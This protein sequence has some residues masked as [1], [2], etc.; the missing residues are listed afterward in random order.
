VEPCPESAS[1]PLEDNAA[2]EVMDVV[3]ELIGLYA[4]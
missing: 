1:D 2:E 3:A 4:E